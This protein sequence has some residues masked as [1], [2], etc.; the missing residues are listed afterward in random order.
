MVW[1]GSILNLDILVILN[2]IILL[3]LLFYN[4]SIIEYCKGTIRGISS[5]SSYKPTS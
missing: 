3:L 1:F 2:A 5:S 4:G